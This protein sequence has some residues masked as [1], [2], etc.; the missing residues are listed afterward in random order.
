[1]EMDDAEVEIS[2]AVREVQGAPVIIRHMCIICKDYLTDWDV[3]NGYAVCWSCRSTYFPVRREFYEERAE[4]IEA[5]LPRRR[6]RKYT[7]FLFL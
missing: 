7:I 2:D 1:M 5:I 3:Y 4:L 6:V